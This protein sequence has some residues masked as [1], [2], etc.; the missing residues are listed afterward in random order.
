MRNTEDDFRKEIEQAKK[1]LESSAF[2]S[3]EQSIVDTD[4]GIQCDFELPYSSMPKIR[5]NKWI[6]SEKIA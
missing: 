4:G 3:K 1:L 5:T 2:N 6:Q